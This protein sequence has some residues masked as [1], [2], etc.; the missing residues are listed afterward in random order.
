MMVDVMA[1]RGHKKTLRGS[2]GKMSRGGI[3]RRRWEKDRL[4]IFNKRKPRTVIGSSSKRPTQSPRSETQRVTIIKK[5][6]FREKKK[7]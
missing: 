6:Q 4:K 2:K 5:V 7:N 3:T 1:I